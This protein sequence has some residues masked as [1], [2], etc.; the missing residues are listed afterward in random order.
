[1]K[2]TII[3]LFPEMFQGFLTESIV[4]RAVEKGAVELEFVQLR[5]FAV[6]NHKTVDDRPYGGGAG[7]VLMAEPLAQAIRS[8]RDAGTDNRVVLT[9]P[10]GIVYS[11]SIA[12][13]Y[14]ELDHLVLVAGHYEA[15][16]ERISQ[17]ID[18]E[19]SI[20]DYVLT[21]GELPAAVIVDSVV[22]LLPGVLKKE[23]AA[24]VESFFTVAVEE[25]SAAIGP[26]TVID[27]LRLKGVQQ[28][29]LLEYPHYTRPAQWEGHEVPEVLL[30]GNHAQIRKWQLQQAFSIT[31]VRRP[32]LLTK[33]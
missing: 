14:A 5:D 2:I 18:E 27:E 31:K 11:Q 12:Q 32:D 25:L 9:S 4:K 1:M 24:A 7:M 19:V 3:S 33:I 13:K 29:Q 16:D 28:V 6:D 20:G 22:R 10:R 15:N 21:G 30:S 17:E 23:D 26:D 8:V